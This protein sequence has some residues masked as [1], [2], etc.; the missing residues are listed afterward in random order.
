MPGSQ[1]LTE[2]SYSARRGA[3]EPNAKNIWKI[4]AYL[5]YIQPALTNEII[6]DAEERIG[7]KLPSEYLDLLKE[8]NGGYIRFTL[9]ES[10]HRC[11]AGIGPYYPNILDSNLEDGQEY[12]DFELQGLVPFD[13]DGHWNLCLDYRQ[14]TQ[15]PSVS[16]IDVEC[17]HQSL[18]ANSFENYL[19]RLFR[20]IDEEK[21][22]IP[23]ANKLEHLLEA[24]CRRFN[25]N[26]EEPDDFAY[27]YPNY[28]IICSQDEDNND[29]L[30]VS[31]NL[32]KQGFVRENDERYEELKHLMKNTALRYPELP[33]EAFL[34][35]TIGASRE[36]L[37]D[38]CKRL[39][40]EVFPIAHYFL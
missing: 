17:N 12:V 27:G 38:E 20:N 31:P 28:R 39:A 14:D 1:A 40:I 22:V 2:I 3:M 11:I 33:R 4:P 15:H 10:L 24:L 8:Q 19:N 21:L 6:R 23:A 32:V 16:Y 25:Y 13:G 9:P 5:P 34:V 37:L 26:M 18:V 36:A 30:S 7:Y 29:W 35:H